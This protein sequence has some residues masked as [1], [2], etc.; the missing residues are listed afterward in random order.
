MA[1]REISTGSPSR[2]YAAAVGVSTA[3]MARTGTSAPRTTTQIRPSHGF[4]IGKLAA[5][6]GRS[7]AWRAPLDQLVIKARQSAGCGN[8]GAI[9]SDVPSWTAKIAEAF[10]SIQECCE[11]CLPTQ[12]KVDALPRE[13]RRRA[14]Q[15]LRRRRRWVP[16]ASSS[17]TTTTRRPFSNSRST[18]TVYEVQRIR[19]RRL[20]RRGRGTVGRSRR[21]HPRRR[22][23]RDLP[24]RRILA[25]CRERGRVRTATINDGLVRVRYTPDGDLHAEAML[26]FRSWLLSHVPSLAE[27]GAPE[28][29][30]GGLNIEGLAWD[31]RTRTHSCSVCGG[32]RIR[33]ASRSFGSPSTPAWPRGRRRRSGRRP[34]CTSAYRNRQ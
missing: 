33:D 29:D 34:S 9:L 32:R 8:S 30:A 16:A 20:S 4:T 24:H 22:G 3:I 12:D 5:R 26:G 23:W 19:R 14:V 15:R 10:H 11:S 25:L 31:P 17:S 28:P 2:E 18:P 21:P 1:R 7:R 27:S 13:E 6:R